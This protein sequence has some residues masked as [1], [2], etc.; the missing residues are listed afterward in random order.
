MWLPVLWRGVAEPGLPVV[1]QVERSPSADG[2]VA[3][4][5]P[6]RVRWV[7]DEAGVA[8]RKARVIEVLSSSPPPIPAGRYGSPVP[9]ASGGVGSGRHARGPG[10]VTVGRGRRRKGCGGRQQDCV[11]FL[12]SCLRDR[13]A[14][15]RLHYGA[16]FPRSGAK[17]T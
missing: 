13:F 8:S 15:I 3:K 12:L 1:V 2:A 6:R 4:R 5:H 17:I 14:G 10:F 7:D 16:P 9:S 11:G